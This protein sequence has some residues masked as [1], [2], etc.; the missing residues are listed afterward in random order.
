MR[1][2]LW[3]YAEHN[4]DR[5]KLRIAAPAKPPQREPSNRLRSTNS[6]IAL[7]LAA[8]SHPRSLHPDEA[9]SE[10]GPQRPLLS[11]RENKTKIDKLLRL[12][13][14]LNRFLQIAPQQDA[15]GWCQHPRHEGDI[16]PHFP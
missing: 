3:A 10:K 13:R 6:P 4:T 2:S 14:D 5:A 12:L 16:L 1:V 9:P 11:F 15:F 8:R 7:W